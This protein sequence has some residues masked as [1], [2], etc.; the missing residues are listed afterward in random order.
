[1]ERA[2]ASKRQYLMSKP[3]LSPGWIS[4]CNLAVS[5]D[6]CSVILSTA[7]AVAVVGLTKMERKSPNTWSERYPKIIGRRQVWPVTS[8]WEGTPSMARGDIRVRG[9]QEELSGPAITKLAIRNS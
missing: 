6:T 2:F 7:S 5:K 9:W 4:A 3:S 8:F 1:M